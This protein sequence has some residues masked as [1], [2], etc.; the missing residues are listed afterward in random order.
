RAGTGGYPPDLYL[1]GADQHRGWFGA[2]LMTGGA[3]DGR[4]P[5]RAILTHGFVVDGAGRKLSKSLGN[6]VSP[7]RIADTR[8]ADILR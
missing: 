5:F 4:A 1:E 8:G 2:S 7:Q 6:T 3:A